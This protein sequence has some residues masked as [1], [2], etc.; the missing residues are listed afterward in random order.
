MYFALQQDIRERLEGLSG[1]GT[2]TSVGEGYYT[3]AALLLGGC[4]LFYFIVVRMLWRRDDHLDLF[5]GR[6]AGEVA[7]VKPTIEDF[8]D[9][10]EA[11]PIEQLEQGSPVLFSWALEEGRGRTVCIALGPKGSELEL[12]KTQ[13]LP[14]QEQNLRMVS[15]GPLG[16]VLVHDVE[17]KIDDGE[18]IRV[19]RKDASARMLRR[20]TRVPAGFTAAAIPED[21]LSERDTVILNVVD[22]SV[23][24]MGFRSEREFEAGLRL[25]LR[26]ALPRYEE[27]LSLVGRITWTK[28]EVTGLFRAG[29]QFDESL[30]AESLAIANLIYDIR[31]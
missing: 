25:V 20:A 15:P 13:E 30:V 17:R 24:G 1:G 29:L 12:S 21:S 14:E 19:R 2:T 8:V 3:H 7:G 10:E 11:P 28:E 4:A 18:S 31:A 9:L 27:P 22:I 23:S 16:H 5:R 26:L 6:R